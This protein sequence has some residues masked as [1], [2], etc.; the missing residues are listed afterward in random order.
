MTRIICKPV[1]WRALREATCTF[2]TC[3]WGSKSRGKEGVGGRQRQTQAARWG[4]F[5]IPT[6]SPGKQ[7][8]PHSGTQRGDKTW[9]FHFFLRIFSCF[10]QENYLLLTPFPTLYYIPVSF[11]WKCLPLLSQ[12]NRKHEWQ[13]YLKRANN[14]V[15]E[16]WPKLRVRSKQVEWWVREEVARATSQPH[17][18][19]SRV[20]MHISNTYICFAVKFKT[21]LITP[22][23][24][25]NPSH[26]VLS[27]IPTTSSAKSDRFIINAQKIR[28]N[29][30]E[31]YLRRFSTTS[32]FLRGSVTI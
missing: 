24:L 21:D 3:S 25:F 17:R 13:S 4:S 12:L 31:L 6:C 8:G 26:L 29:G 23:R 20:Y 32:S 22:K 15:D 11:L 9:A 18:N 30:S 16:E 7:P 5:H 10:L 1:C 27:N 14:A 28:Q 19:E 2:Q